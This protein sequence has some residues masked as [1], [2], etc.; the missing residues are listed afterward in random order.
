MFNLCHVIQSHIIVGGKVAIHC[1]AGFG[2]TGVAIAAT[3]LFMEPGGNPHRIIDDIRSRRRKCVQTWVQQRFVVEFAEVISDL[4][5]IYGNPN[6]KPEPFPYDF[7]AERK[8]Q[9]LLKQRDD[10]DVDKEAAAPPP[11]KPLQALASMVPWMR[12][13]REFVE[14]QRIGCTRSIGDIYFAV[15]GSSVTLKEAMAR[16]QLLTHHGDKTVAD[17]MIPRIVS[18]LVTIL[19]QHCRNDPISVAASIFGVGSSAWPGKG[20]SAE[21]DEAFDI[22]YPSKQDDN[23]ESGGA[24]A[25]GSLMSTALASPNT[26][27]EIRQVSLDDFEPEGAAEDASSVAT[28]GDPVEP[29]FTPPSW[30]VFDEETLENIKVQ[31]R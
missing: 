18:S 25:T 4:R 5:R 17:R 2:R 16:Q 1:H 3:M 14:R 7:A 27:R 23:E 19:L 31:V 29:V 10:R 24:G 22:V 20:R 21:W 12:K 13:S 15:E 11:L 28:L 6:G 8:V 30:D 9:K 26:K